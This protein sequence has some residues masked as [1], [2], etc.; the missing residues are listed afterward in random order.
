MVLLKVHSRRYIFVVLV[1][2]CSCVFLLSCLGCSKTRFVEEF[3]TGLDLLLFVMLTLNFRCHFH[4]R[5]REHYMNVLR[6]L[7]HTNKDC[8]RWIDLLIWAFE[9][10]KG[11]YMNSYSHLQILVPEVYNDICLLEISFKDTLLFFLLE[12]DRLKEFVHIYIV[13]LQA[14]SMDFIDCCCVMFFFLLWTRR[15]HNFFCPVLNTEL[16]LRYCF[17]LFICC[18]L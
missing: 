14:L 10:L 13:F 1:C 8:R 17:F 5:W 3:R 11:I 12:F 6:C 15:T 7:L 16:A 4:Y 9:S 18:K 2:L